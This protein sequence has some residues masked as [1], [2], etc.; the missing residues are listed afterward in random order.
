MTTRK[1]SLTTP[2][3]NPQSNPKRVDEL[4]KQFAS[5]RFGKTERTNSFLKDPISFTTENKDIEDS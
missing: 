4:R 3:K 1:K 5:A 2:S